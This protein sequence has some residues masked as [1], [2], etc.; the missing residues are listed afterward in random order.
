M[1]C[2]I[3]G[4]LSKQLDGCAYSHAPICK[5][6]LHLQQLPAYRRLPSRAERGVEVRDWKSGMAMTRYARPV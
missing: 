3:Y 5:Y 4:V 1:R 2:L 6:R